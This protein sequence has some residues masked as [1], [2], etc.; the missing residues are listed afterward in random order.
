MASMG[1][2][3]TSRDSNTNA[4]ATWTMLAN[5]EQY[6]KFPTKS[7]LFFYRPEAKHFWICAPGFATV[8]KEPRI[9]SIVD[10]RGDEPFS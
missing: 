2:A 8:D 5:N 6:P 1:F 9:L 10:G 4:P 3:D 7:K